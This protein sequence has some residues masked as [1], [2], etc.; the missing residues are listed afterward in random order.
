[1]TH[2]AVPDARIL[3]VIAA[4][5]G[6]APDA[7]WLGE[8]DGVWYRAVDGSLRTICQR[9]TRYWCDVEAALAHVQP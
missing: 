4:D 9:G 6:L 8:A 3:A 2:A 5:A 7:V 1:M